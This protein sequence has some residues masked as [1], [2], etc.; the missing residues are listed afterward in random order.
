MVVLA[1]YVEG[2]AIALARLG[3]IDEEEIA[4]VFVAA[5]VLQRDDGFR[6]LGSLAAVVTK[7]RTVQVLH[8]GIGPVGRLRGTHSRKCRGDHRGQDGFLHDF[9]IFCQTTHH[10]APCRAATFL[11]GR[12]PDAVKRCHHFCSIS[13]V[14]DEP[15][16]DHF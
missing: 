14:W 6:E 15:A 13:A 3:E 7:L 10:P 11:P 2:V 1:V 9:S 8:F 4:T 12:P 16:P 5:G